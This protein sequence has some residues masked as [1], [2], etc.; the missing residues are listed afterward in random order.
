MNRRLFA[1]LVCVALLVALLPA[2]ASAEGSGAIQ[3]GTDGIGAD[4]YIYFGKYSTYDVPWLVLSKAALPETSTAAANTLSLLS[5]YG[6][7]SAAFQSS[8]SGYYPGSTLQSAMTAVYNGF[9]LRE[10]GAIAVTALDGSSMHAT[11]SDLGGQKL[12]PLSQNELSDSSKHQIKPITNQ[13]GLRVFDWWLRSSESAQF[14]YEW[15]T[16]VV[17]RGSVANSRYIRPA[18]HLDLSKVL[19][20]SAAA[21][22]KSTAGMESGLAAVSTTLPTEW[23]LTLKDNAPG[24]GRENFDVSTAAVSATTEGGIVSIV[25]S[26]A[27]VSTDSA[28]EYLSAMIVDSSDNALYYGRLKSIAAEADA[29]GTQEIA[30]PSGLAAGSY[31]LRIFNEQYN[32]DKKTDYS[33]AFED[34]TLTVTAPVPPT[35]TDPTVNR[36]VPVTVGSPATFSVTA[37]GATGYQWQINRNDGNDFVPISGATGASYTTAP[38]TL[39]NNGYQYYCVATSNGGSITSPVFTLNVTEPMDVPATGDSS[40][41]IL[42][43]GILLLAGAILTVNTALYRGKRKT[44]N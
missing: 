25:Y 36:T 38:V 5:K 42:W 20:T 27:K 43:L 8:G 3:L 44:G 32:G 9:D 12:F 34:V 14:A 31:T 40:T 22:G 33:S 21:G 1:A 16:T 15:Y 7:G 6:L 28:P 35:V 11:Q 18:F 24:S 39:A 4:D 41:P 30:I 10:Q 37:T 13:T 17:I 26:G 23:K 29:G 19:F 2:T